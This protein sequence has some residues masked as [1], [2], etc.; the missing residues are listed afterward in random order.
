MCKIFDVNEL[1]SECEIA[2][3]MET[4]EKEENVYP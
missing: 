2:D 4:M 3:F 1:T